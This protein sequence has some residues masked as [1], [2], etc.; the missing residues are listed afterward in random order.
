MA[1]ETTGSKQFGAFKGVF[2]P[3]FL[4]IV[5]VILF[6]RMGS[7]VGG[8]GLGGAIIIILLAVSV[9]LSTGLSIS[10][11]ASNIN[12]GSGGAYSIINKTLGL[13]IGGSIGL[14]LYLAQTFSVALYIFGFA[15]V[16]NYIFAGY[17]ITIISLIAFLVLFILT[18]F[19]TKAA[20]KLQ[21]GVLA[22][23]LFALLSIFMGKG[24]D[25]TSIQ[26]AQGIA[27]GAEFWHLFALFFPAVTGLMAGIGMSGELSNPKKQIP[28]G[29]LYG[30]GAST[31]IYI[32]VSVLLAYSA[33]PEVLVN[34]TLILA[35]ISAFTSLVIFGVLAATF[36]SALTVMIAAPRVLEA[37]AENNVLP[38]SDFLTKDK[39][40]EEPRNAVLVTGLILTPV[41]LTGGLNSVAQILTIFFLIAY[42]I[43]NLAVFLEQFLGL[44][45]F[46]PLF[47]IPKAVPLFGAVI[48]LL[49]MFLV[50]VSAGVLSILFVCVVYY[51]LTKKNLPNK[52]K[53]DVRSGV[54]RAFSEWAAEQTRR[55][56]ES[57][58]HIWK[59]NMV[60]PVLST[61]TVIG[62]FPLIKS[63]IYPRGRITVLGFNLLDNVEDN[64]EEKDITRKELKRELIELPDLVE[65]FNGDKIFTSYSTIDA[66]NYVDSLI[67][68][69]DT[70]Q[71]QVFSPN[72]LFLPYAPHNLEKDDFL[73]IIRS[74]A[75]KRCGLMF[76][77]KNKEVGLGV[78]EDIHVWIT[79]KV[80]KEDLFKNRH[81]DLASLIAYSIKSNWNG[82]IT[83]WMCVDE[84]Q[85]KERAEKYLNKLIYEARLPQST[86]TQVR[87]GKFKKVLKESPQGDIH[88]FPF[89]R[90]DTESIYKISKNKKR[91]TLFVLDSTRESILA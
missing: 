48:S 13:E 44:R 14:P 60:L 41:I 89:E 85:K 32:G 29:I 31:L 65:D 9:T 5:G 4:S 16:W 37:L 81:Y 67:V 20:V 36:S 8:A 39:T 15:E 6:L 3:T 54:F 80:V 18:F 73:K 30:L 10:S 91:T 25:Y 53:G 82:D 19:S 75:K 78:K 56:P 21:V 45:S 38:G 63:I 70:I 43:I 46:R 77:D 26:V 74:S 55:L 17:N 2:I 83:F 68:A 88:I 47:K 28:R 86:K 72:V 64:P 34:E 76:F 23:T 87:V 12:I 57:Y 66:A 22:V 33:G 79:S 71:S 51:L 58:L 7:I 50:S 61:K 24:V 1:K 27:E 84:T 90:S 59:P 62:S 69:M 49:A 40:E 35:D 42:A 11:I 52:E